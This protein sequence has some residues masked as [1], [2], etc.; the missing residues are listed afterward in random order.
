[1]TIVFDTVLLRP[2]CVLLQ[3]ALGGTTPSSKFFALFPSETWLVSITPNMRCY[4]VTEPQL[5]RLQA[6]ACKVVEVSDVG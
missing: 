2:G 3:A 5:L 6:L 1:M 4:R